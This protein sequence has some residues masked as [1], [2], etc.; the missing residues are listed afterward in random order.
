MATSFLSRHWRPALL[1]F[2][3]LGSLVG[4]LL[5]PPIPQDLH[6]HDF[7]DR[8][9]LLGIPNFGDVMSNLPFLVIGLAGLVACRRAVLGETALC[10][11]IFFVGVALV[12]VGSG[13]YHWSPDNR[14]LV[15][16]RLPM[17]IG[18]M[19]MF[20]ALLAESVDGRLAR[21]AL[22]PALAVGIAS[23]GYWAKYDDLRFYAWVQFCPLLIIPVLLALFRSRYTHQGWLI[24][25]LGF[26]LLAKVFEAGDRRIFGFTGG[27]VGG[28]A[29]KHLLAGAGCW[30]I[31]EMLR[32]RTV[33]A[34]GEGQVGKDRWGRTGGEGQVGG[35]LRRD[36]G[37]E[38]AEGA[39]Q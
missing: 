20:V 9:A 5:W 37:N 6:Y 39:L 3:M 34:G 19:A 4:L 14:T 25:A 38:N 16:D 7:A 10:W 18:F 17:T 2:I 24:V 29:I 23:V 27:V 15:W 1:I 26:Y 22:G 12:S 36:M 13:Y 11:K 35:A 32:R 30:A 33:R 21:Y 31:L 8:R 28:H